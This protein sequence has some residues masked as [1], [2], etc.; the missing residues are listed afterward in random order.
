[1]SKHKEW[2]RIDQEGE[3]PTVSLTPTEHEQFCDY[4][5]GWTIPIILS[6]LLPHKLKI[7]L[8]FS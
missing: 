8:K 4:I 1:M 5:S 3:I 6:G 7:L 2:M